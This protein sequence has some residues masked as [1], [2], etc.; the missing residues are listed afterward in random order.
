MD[1]TKSYVRD[2]N[3]IAFELNIAVKAV[4]QSFYCNDTH[5]HEDGLCLRSFST[6]YKEIPCL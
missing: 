1:I 5:V 3:V 4:N 6:F 2:T